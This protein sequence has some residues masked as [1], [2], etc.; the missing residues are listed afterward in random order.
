M[1]SRRRRQNLK[2]SGAAKIEKIVRENPVDR[3]A[4]GVR[5]RRAEFVTRDA[6]HAAGRGF[7]R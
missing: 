3:F 5:M 1:K 2:G 7:A 4:E 6:K